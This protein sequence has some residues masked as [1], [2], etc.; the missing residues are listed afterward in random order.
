V[1]DE[2]ASSPLIPSWVNYL[3]IEGVIGA[4]KTSL[5]TMIADRLDGAPCARRGAG[6]TPF[7]SILSESKI[8]RFS[9]AALVSCARFK[10]L[11]GY[12]DQQDMFS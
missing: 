11:S 5:C 10:K 6:E 9:D 7:W 4:G 8:L 12:I 1:T 2:A 3:C